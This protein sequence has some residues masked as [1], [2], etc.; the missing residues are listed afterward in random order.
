MYRLAGEIAE[1]TVATGGE[2]RAARR[3]VGTLRKVID[4][5]IA[6]A[7]TLAKARRRFGRLVEFLQLAA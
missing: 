7:A 4:A 3:V 1:S 5:P 2:R 6:D